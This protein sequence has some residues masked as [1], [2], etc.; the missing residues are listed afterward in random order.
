[1]KRKIAIIISIL[2]LLIV[3]LLIIFNN[4]KKNIEYISFANLTSEDVKNYQNTSIKDEDKIKEIVKKLKNGENLYKVEIQEMNSNLKYEIKISYFEGVEE[5]NNFIE[6]N[7]VLLFA[8]VPEAGSITISYRSKEYGFST[9]QCFLR[10]VYENKYKKDD[11]SYYLTHQTYF[12]KEVINQQVV[13]YYIPDRIIYKDRKKE[14]IYVFT[15]DD[16]FYDELVE[17]M[18]EY[19]KVTQINNYNATFKEQNLENFLYSGKNYIAFDYNS[20]DENN[21]KVA[22]CLEISDKNELKSFLDDKI[23]FRKSYNIDNTK[24]IDINIEIGDITSENKEK[25]TEKYKNAVYQITLSNKSELKDFEKTFNIDLGIN[26]KNNTKIIVTISK[27]KIEKIDWTLHKIIYNFSNFTQNYNVNVFVVDNSI[28]SNNIEYKIKTR[29]YIKGIVTQINKNTITVESGLEYI[30]DIYDTITYQKIDVAVDESTKIYNL[31]YRD[32]NN[33]YKE[34]SF[35]DIKVGDQVTV[36]SNRLPDKLEN[37]ILAD[38][39]SVVPKSELEKLK[40]TLG[41]KTRIDGGIIAGDLNEDGEGTIVFL[42]TLDG[43]TFIAMKI[44]VT[45]DTKVFYLDDT[46]LENEKIKYYGIVTV[47][48]KEAIGNIDSN[49]PTAKLIDIYGD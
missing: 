47:E 21:Q 45:K 5:N 1:M 42:A 7:V 46:K 23:K 4:K 17:K 13:S 41:E 9:G 34:M 36:N 14:K 33:N 3:M 19:M 27:Y 48:L 11:L 22:H 24:S 10:Y 35:L 18:F 20:T 25:L 2:V 6:E 43:Y 44:N 29:H 26:Y 31:T 28:N 38:E 32:K 15:K 37:T 40:E 16:D 12:E 39:M 49:I 30:E 8:L